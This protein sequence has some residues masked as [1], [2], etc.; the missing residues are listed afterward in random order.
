[1]RTLAVPFEA[2]ERAVGCGTLGKASSS[3]K[4]IV[5][6]ILDR[7]IQRN[8]Y[9]A[10]KLRCESWAFWSRHFFFFFFFHSFS[11]FPIPPHTYI[12]T[13]NRGRRR[14]LRK[15]KKRKEKI[16]TADVSHL[17]ISDERHRDRICRSIKLLAR[18]L[19]TSS[20]LLIA[21]SS[22]WLEWVDDDGRWWKRWEGGKGDGGGGCYL[23]F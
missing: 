5:F 8:C 2:A 10:E 3:Y 4:Y 15:E 23:S 19:E 17:L 12:H 6:C 9:I 16:K 11:P 20:L 7:C 18:A 14:A 13:Y 22:T 1:M 21:G